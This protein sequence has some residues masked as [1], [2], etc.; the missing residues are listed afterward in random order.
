MLSRPG[1]V[2]QAEALLARVRVSA[3]PLAVQDM[4]GCGSQ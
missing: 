1:T 4:H 2:T 3:G